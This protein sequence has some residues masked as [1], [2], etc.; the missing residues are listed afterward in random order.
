MLNRCP[1]CWKKVK[2]GKVMENGD[3]RQ[4]IVCGIRKIEGISIFDEFICE[5]CEFEIIRTDVKDERY[6]YFIKQM[7][8]I[9]LKKNA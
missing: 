9:W 8:Q 7:K 3:L 5:P 2:V 4:C 1:K 6:P